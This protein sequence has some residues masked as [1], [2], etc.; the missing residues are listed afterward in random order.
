MTRSIRQ[1]ALR[2]PFCRKRRRPGIR[3]GVG[4]PLRFEKLEERLALSLASPWDSFPA[5]DPFATAAGNDSNRVAYVESQGSDGDSRDA[6]IDLGAVNGT[7]AVNGYVGGTD[8]VD[9]YRF[10]LNRTAEVD[11][12]LTGLQ[13]DIDLYLLDAAGGQLAH[14]IR[15]GNQSEA[16]GRTLAAGEY[17][18]KV[19]PFGS[20]ASSYGLTVEAVLAGQPPA[21]ESGDTFDD[22]QWLGSLAAPRTLEETVGGEDSADYYRF[23]LDADAEVAMR[24][25]GLRADVDLYLFGSDGREL[26]RSWNGGSRDESLHLSLD[27]GEYVVLVKPWGSAE[28]PYLLRM[29]A[30]LKQ[31]ETDSPPDPPP[32]DDGPYPDVA[33]FGGADDWN[34]NS[35][36]AP[37]VWAQG[38]TGEGVVVAVVDTGVDGSHRELSSRMWVNP[39]EVPGNGIDDDGNGFI[40]DIHGWD[41]VGSDNNPADGNGHGTH[42][43]GTIAAANDGFGATG[44]AF[45]ATIMPVRVLDSNGAGSLSDVAAGIRYAVD[46]GAQ[47]INLS[48]GGSYSSVVHSALAYAG[49]HGVF[50]VAAAGNEGGATPLYPAAFSAEFTHV[51]SVGAHDSNNARAYFSNGVGASGAVQVAAPG[52]G[53]LS[54]LPGNRYGRLS[55]TSMAAPHVAGLAALALS[56]NPTLDTQTLRSLIVEGADRAIAGS[57]A[58]GGVN[59][60]L[61][62]ARAERHTS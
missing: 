25:T 39:G 57:D 38:F 17:F 55:G 42:V 14:S 36:Q 22:A 58:S 15:P 60:A 61:S 31:P 5:I 2:A 43:A 13:Q 12:A 53:V 6:A 7:R 27:A 35:V 8:H 20:N 44:V 18:I 19:V 21:G 34:L 4:S 26:A 56:A 62:V 23:R 40:D 54:C 47:V 16:L 45:G 28:S 46:N 33:D 41:F 49:Q 52:V 32:A 30:E 3:S 48:L 29:Q 24:L 9:Y 59:G 37:E 50:V 10:E 11:F 1:G 51:L